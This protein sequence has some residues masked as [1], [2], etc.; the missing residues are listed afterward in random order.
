MHAHATKVQIQLKKNTLKKIKQYFFNPQIKILQQVIQG[1]SSIII[2]P[3]LPL[4]MASSLESAS[5][6]SFRR[7]PEGV[8][9]DPKGGVVPFV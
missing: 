3:L 4:G 5:R 6:L 8:G 1:Q 2:L 7:Y 9:I